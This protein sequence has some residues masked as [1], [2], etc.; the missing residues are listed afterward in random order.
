MEFTFDDSPLQRLLDSLNR[1]DSL[2]AMKFLAT[3]EGEEELLAED[4]A[5]QLEEKG[6]LLDISTLPPADG[7]EARV[8]LRRE[9]ELAQ[10]GALLEKLEDT[11]PLAICLREIAGQSPCEDPDR[12]AAL[13]AAGDK[14]AMEQLTKG[15]LPH[16]VELAKAHVGRGVLLLDL[17]Q[18]GSLGLWQ[19]VLHYE[20]GD[21]V[22]QA[23]WYIRSAMGRLV[24][25]QARSQGVGENLSAALQRY[26]QADRE[27]L[28]RLG[29]NPTREEL[30]LEM[31]ITPEEVGALQS[32]LETVEAVAKTRASA[33][34][35]APQPE[36]EQPVEDTAYF[37]M[38]QRIGELL[39]VL[40]EQDAKI[41]SLRFGL[42]GGK[43][44]NPQ[45]IGDL[46]QLT[47]EEV[48]QREARALQILRKE[49]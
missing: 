35:K 46:L 5:L 33:A 15:Q 13:A 19:S 26:R 31:H 25:L 1:G 38:R 14:A 3:L 30:A 7:G 41:L 4:A 49:N 44:M 16:V 29:H 37:Q 24:T 8:R 43:P 23:D 28:T 36:D 17:I 40:E 10:A 27:L 22:S 11:D 12:L 34:E 6:V 32:M 2:S 42:E 47:A 9:Q 48:L 18:E 20:S 21:F 39:S 45:Q